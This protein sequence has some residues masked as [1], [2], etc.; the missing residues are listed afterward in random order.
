MPKW[1][2]LIV[3]LGYDW[4]I[5]QTAKCIDELVAL[6]RPGAVGDNDDLFVGAKAAEY[7]PPPI[8]ISCKPGDSL[9]HIED[10][11]IDAVVMDPPYYDNVMYAELSDFFYVWLKRTAGHIF[12]ELFRRHLTDKDNEAVANP[13]RFRGEKGAKA[14]AGRDYQERMASIFAECRRVLKPEGIMTLM[15]THKATG[16]WDALTKGLMEAGFVITA[17][18]PVNTEAEG[19]LHIR[20]KAAANSTI[21][22]VC[23]PRGDRDGSG[24]VVYWEDVELRVEKAVRARIEA[25]QEAGIAGVDLYLASFGPALEEFSRHWPLKRGTPR[26]RPEER[27]RR[28]QPVLLEDEWDPYAATP[29]DALDAARREVKRWRLEELTH[30]KADADLDPATAFFVLA[31]DAFRAPVFS[32]DEALRL[33]RAV[34]ANLDGDIVG[35]LAGKKGSDLVLWDSAHRAAKGALGP[36]DGSRGMIDAIH[37]GANLARLRSLATARELLAGKRVDRDPR[38]FAALEAVLEVLPMSRAFTGIDLEGEAAASGEDFEVLY[39]LNKLSRPAFRSPSMSR[40]SSDSGAPISPD[41]AA[42]SR[43]APQVHHRG[44]RS[45]PAV[46]CACARGRGALRPA[47]GV[48]Q[49]GRP[50]ARGARH[51]R[52]GAKRWPHEARRRLHPGAAGDRGDR[53]GRAAPPPRRTAPDRSSARPAR[54]GLGRRVGTAGMDGRARIPGSE[55]RRA[56]RRGRHADRGERHLP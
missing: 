14:L 39:K 4:A 52:S 48:F 42:G 46:L 16:A 3:G 53:A 20:N 40:S 13:V 31:W 8:T 23:R 38:F 33:A 25:F 35:R 34:G 21:F 55:G 32:Y 19:S 26:E 41:H 2:R 27:R 47:D 24:E 49:R 22:L 54:S 30:R 18:W 37:H 9:D 44:R 5:G 17:S 11:S 7:M 50:G 45:R 1:P 12:P 29:E 43:M 6:V 28:R 56:L 51:R 15:F 36:A 10:G